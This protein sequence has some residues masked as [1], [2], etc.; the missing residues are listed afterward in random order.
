HRLLR[1]RLPNATTTASA[2]G[3]SRA[4]LYTKV[5]PVD[6]AAKSSPRRPPRDLHLTSSGWFARSPN[7][8]ANESRDVRR[9]PPQERPRPRVARGDLRGAG[10]LPAL[11]VLADAAETGKSLGDR[12]PIVAR[13]PRAP[14]RLHRPVDAPGVVA[15]PAVDDPTVGPR[16]CRRRRPRAPGRRL[17]PPSLV[18]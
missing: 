3:C 13:L 16:L 5:Y 14:V 8:R 1:G 11:G 9:S 6:A 4:I 18:R 2:A 17:S 15:R 7:H 10:R 12:P